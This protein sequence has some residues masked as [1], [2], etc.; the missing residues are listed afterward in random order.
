MFALVTILI[1]VIA[2]WLIVAVLWRTSRSNSQSQLTESKVAAEYRGLFVPSE[3]EIKRLQAD[4]KALLLSKNQANSNENLR[5]RIKDGDFSALIEAQE[6]E[7]A[8]LYEELLWILL[9]KDD[10]S[11]LLTF[12]RQHDKLPVSRLMLENLRMIWCEYP[13]RQATIDYLHFAARSPSI[14]LFSE[15]VDEIVEFWQTER[16]PMFSAEH[17]KLLIESE[18][19]TLAADEKSSGAGF[20]LKQKLAGLRLKLST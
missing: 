9:E 8:N 10:F 6:S 19:W 18:F 15:A 3:A 4:E 20:L 12:F 13:T 16:L 17:L 5:R 1:S 11:E 7:D 14:E 2:A